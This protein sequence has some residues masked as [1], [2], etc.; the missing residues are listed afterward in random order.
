V[1]PFIEGLRNSGLVRVKGTGVFLTGNQDAMPPALVRMTKHTTVLHKNVLLLTISLEDV[2]RVAD[3]ER[4]ELQ[5]LGSGVYRAVAHYGF[6]EEVDVQ[7][8]MDL[9]RKPGFE[10]DPDDTT[11]FL[12]RERLVAPPGTRGLRLWRQRLFAWMAQN[13]QPA[14][15]FFRIPP[16]R[17][18]EVGAQIA[19]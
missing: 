12:G 18:V 13:A 9:L 16:E 1:R 19:P 15:A 14:P 7:R 10:H 8:V 6:M 5:E 3:A 11:Y 2:A 17:V 4:I